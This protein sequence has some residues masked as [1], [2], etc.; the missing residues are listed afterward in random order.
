MPAPHWPAP[1]AATPVTA[2]VPLPGSKSVTNRALLLAALAD[3]PGIVRQA[4]RSRDADL[5]ASALRSLGTT[6]TPTRESAAGVDWHVTPGPIRGGAHVDVGLAGT[7]MRFVPPMAAL[8]DGPISFDG[9]PHARKRPMGPILDALR[10]LGARIDNDA[11]PFTISGPLTGGEV[12]L[13]A[14]GSSQFVSG[15]LLTAA[16]F[17]KGVEI[18]HV[19]PPVPSQPHIEMTIEMLRAAGVAVDDSEPDV[20][21]VAPGPIAARDMTVEPDLSNAA[22]FLAAALVTSGTV[23]IPGWPLTTTQAGDALRDLLTQMGAEVT[24]ATPTPSPEPTGSSDTPTPK[25]TRSTDTPTPETTP[26]TGTPDPKVTRFTDTPSPEATRSADS[27]SAIATGPSPSSPASPHSSAGS[28]TGTTAATG[29]GV[30]DLVVRGT[31][32]I[33]GI[34]ADLHEVGELTP[35][36]AALAALASTPSRIRGVGHLRGHETDR[37]AALATEINRLGGDA[38]ETEDGLIIRPRPLHGGTFHSYDDHRMATAG[39]VIGLAVPGVE[40]E[41]IATTAKTLPEFVQMWTAMLDA[42]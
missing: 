12:V 8:A 25:I 4:L 7:V 9:D 29:S 41:N 3:G 36:I 1:V 19:G 24:R 38:E 39:A 2:T 27:P 18:R 17:E 40:V 30:T 22:P 28:N 42:R 23:T 13:D 6:L 34:D 5:M 15:L 14:S 11:L 32:V 26:S 20:W 10:A 37:L 31:G 35:T 21:R 16:R 33:T